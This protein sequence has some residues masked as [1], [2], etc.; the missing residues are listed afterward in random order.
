MGNDGGLI[1]KEEPVLEKVKTSTAIPVKIQTTS[2]KIS[3]LQN[4]CKVELERA[5]GSGEINYHI[6]WALGDYVYPKEQFA[7]QEGGAAKTYTPLVRF[8]EKTKGVKA[9]ELIASYVTYADVVTKN[10]RK[11]GEHSG[12]LAKYFLES[13]MKLDDTLRLYDGKTIKVKD[14]LKR[15][16][17]GTFGKYGF[18]EEPSW[19]LHALAVAEIEKHTFRVYM[20]QDEEGREKKGKYETWNIEKLAKFVEGEVKRTFLPYEETSK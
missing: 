11:V 12:S 15:I 16:D 9:S 6:I 20:D 1:F 13:G 2:T 3:E 17:V 4:R 10:S 19:Y 8:L 5:R 14:L 18:S 7:K